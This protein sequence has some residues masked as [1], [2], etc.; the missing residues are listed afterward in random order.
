M[1][2]LLEVCL[3]IYLLLLSFFD[4]TISYF[5]KKIYKKV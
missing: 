4:P 5:I 2:I 1:N 3:F